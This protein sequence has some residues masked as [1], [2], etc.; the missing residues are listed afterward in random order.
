MITPITAL[1]DACSMQWAKDSARKGPRLRKS[2]I[3]LV[4][5]RAC[6]EARSSRLQIALRWPKPVGSNSRTV[7]ATEAQVP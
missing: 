1:T 3:S 2:T 7:M 6:K 4:V 5:P